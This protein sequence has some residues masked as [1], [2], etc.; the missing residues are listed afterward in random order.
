[1]NSYKTVR[2]LSLLERIEKDSSEIILSSDEITKEIK[3]GYFKS[4]R[5]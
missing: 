4:R 3:H 2:I 5:S 1:M